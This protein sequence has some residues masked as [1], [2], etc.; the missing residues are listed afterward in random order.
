MI[1]ALEAELQQQ[2]PELP[3]VVEIE[4]PPQD[5]PDAV[6]P[7]E[8]E[9]EDVEEIQVI[10]ELIVDEDE[11]HALQENGDIASDS[12]EDGESEYIQS[13]DDDEEEEYCA[14][15]LRFALQATGV[16]P[17]YV[18]ICMAPCKHGQNLESSLRWLIACVQKE[19]ENKGHSCLPRVW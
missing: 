11:S 19:E 3:P 5:S 7:V 8:V 2:E 10:G 14:T 9:M 12:P 4:I 15:R 6:V 1:P 16:L 17:S 13:S 18:S